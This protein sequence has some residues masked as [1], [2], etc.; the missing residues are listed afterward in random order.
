MM[1]LWS[2]LAGSCTQLSISFWDNFT[3]L[4][5]PLVCK[6]PFDARSFR[7]LYSMTL[8]SLRRRAILA[9]VGSCAAFWIALLVLIYTIINF[10]GYA[11]SL[12]TASGHSAFSRSPT[13][14]EDGIV[15]L[16]KVKVIKE[17]SEGEPVCGRRP[18]SGR[19]ALQ[20]AI[21]LE[22]ST[23]TLS[24]HALLVCLTRLSRW[25]SCFHCIW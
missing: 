9:A 23:F 16:D 14:V 8:W 10:I 22:P 3:S 18:C 4:F 24:L 7:Q 12:H 20:G 6:V 1:S 21:S 15:L 11:G 13:C 2:Q 5:A 19:S 25:P 17:P